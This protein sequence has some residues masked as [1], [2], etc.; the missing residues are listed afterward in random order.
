M[1]KSFALVSLVLFASYVSPSFAQMPGPPDPFQG[2]RQEQDACRP[3]VTR[4]CKE[5][6]PDTFRIL[7]CLQAHRPKLS[8]ACRV[9]LENHGQ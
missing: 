4:F 1:V 8:K 6:I 5:F 7:A 3:N 9:V 2:T